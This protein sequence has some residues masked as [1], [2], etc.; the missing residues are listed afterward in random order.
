MIKQTGAYKY[1]YKFKYYVHRQIK[2]VNATCNLVTMRY[3][4]QLQCGMYHR[5]PTWVEKK[6]NISLSDG[7]GGGLGGLGAYALLRVLGGTPPPSPPPSSRRVLA[8]SL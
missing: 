2:Y 6:K 1:N 4:T 8:V 5:H 3:M 7:E